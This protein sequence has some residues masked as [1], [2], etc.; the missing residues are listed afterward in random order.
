[1]SQNP[2]PEDKRHFRGRLHGKLKSHFLLDEYDRPKYSTLSDG[3]RQYDME[4]FL[5]SP[6]SDNINS[7]SYFINDPTFVG[8]ACS[9]QNASKRFT[10]EISSY[11][12]VE[13]IVTVTMKDGSTFRHS[14]QL[15]DM[16][17]TGLEEEEE[18]YDKS[19]RMAIT[20]AMNRILAN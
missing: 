18:Y 12:D 2:S 9:S 14:E 4:L 6:L 8:N 15:S 17:E 13:I 3:M 11:G 7:V 20:D 16:L 1:M 5:E 10:V 19:N